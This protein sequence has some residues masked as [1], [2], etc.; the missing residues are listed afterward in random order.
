M[1]QDNAAA[2]KKQAPAAGGKRGAQATKSPAKA[3]LFKFWGVQFLK[4]LTMVN[5]SFVKTADMASDPP[6]TP[7]FAMASK[8]PLRAS[9]EP[10]PSRGPPWS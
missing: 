4:R 7:S 1:P 5:A 3:G 10:T 8:C 2:L 6:G 9:L